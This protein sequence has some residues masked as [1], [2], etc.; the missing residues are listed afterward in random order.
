[1]RHEKKKQ[2]SVTHSK[3]KKARKMACENTQISNLTKTSKQ[4]YIYV[5]IIKGSHP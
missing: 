2:E 4:D 1:M 5:Q 3:Q